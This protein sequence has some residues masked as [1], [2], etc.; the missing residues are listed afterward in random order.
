METEKESFYVA[1]GKL[2]TQTAKE[3]KLNIPAIKRASGLQY[4]TIKR[5]MS[6][7]GFMF[8]Q[9]A[10]IAEVLKLDLN[11]VAEYALNYEGSHDKEKIEDLI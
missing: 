7:D 11:S 6:G 4:T 3:R 8:H 5:M 9:I 10:V 2:L 1:V